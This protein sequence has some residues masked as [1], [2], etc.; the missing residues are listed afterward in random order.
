MKYVALLEQR[1]ASS[2]RMLACIQYSMIRRVFEIPQIHVRDRPEELVSELM[3][4][5]G[6][7]YIS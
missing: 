4:M 1:S 2:L 5:Q 6:P 3:S 7:Y